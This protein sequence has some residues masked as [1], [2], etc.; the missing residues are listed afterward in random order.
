MVNE[1]AEQ[2]Y[3]VLAADMFNGQVATTPDQ[4]MRLAGAVR[5]NPSEAIANLQAAVGYLGSLENVN[6]SRIASLGWCFGGDQS[7]Q[8]ALISEKNPLASTVIYYGNL[9][10]DEQKLS[11]IRWPVLGIFGDQ[12]DSIS[13][14]NVTKFE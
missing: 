7:L 3:V 5:E 6:S 4:A 14:E 11:K 9:V 8:L 12:D 2:G 13:V 1:L 10:L